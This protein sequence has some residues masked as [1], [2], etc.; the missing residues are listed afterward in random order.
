MSNREYR[1]DTYEFLRNAHGF[2]ILYNDSKDRNGIHYI[3]VL[4][5]IREGEIVAT[6]EFTTLKAFMKYLEGIVIL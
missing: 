4:G 1:G 3:A 6:W 2:R 5:D